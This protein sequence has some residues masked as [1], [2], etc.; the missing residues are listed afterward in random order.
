MS[1]WRRTAP[2]RSWCGT[3]VGASRSARPTISSPARGWAR[4]ARSCEA[5]G[6]VAARVGNDGAVSSPVTL[7]S[8]P[9]YGHLAL[10]FDGSGYLLLREELDEDVPLNT[11]GMRLAIDGTPLDPAWIPIF[12]EH[13]FEA[14]ASGGGQHLL[15]WKESEEL[16]PNE[17]QVSVRAARVTPAGEVLDPQ[18]IVVDEHVGCHDD[19]KQ[20]TEAVTYAG[21]AFLLTWTMPTAACTEGSSA[22][23][24][25]SLD[26]AGV[27]GPVSTIEEDLGAEALASNGS[28]ALFAYTRYVQEAPY[29]NDRLRARI[30]QMPAPPACPGGEGCEPEPP[31]EPEEPEPC[32]GAC[33]D[34]DAPTGDPPPFGGCSVASAPATPA[35]LAALAL[36]GLAAAM[37]RRRKPCGPR[38]RQG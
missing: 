6:L 14:S 5:G 33:G 38:R 22:R 37:S 23:R 24:V 36:L 17:W 11:L 31:E 12:P 16:A 4:T 13:G 10:S 2:A 20:V 9:F 18:G 25:A 8:P 32:T 1:T 26:A 15:L 30:V 29:Q 7:A 21:S 3:I 28:G 19:I 27:L 35:P 34:P